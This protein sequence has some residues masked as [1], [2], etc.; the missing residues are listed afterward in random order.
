MYNLAEKINNKKSKP[1]ELVLYWI[2]GV[3]YIIKYNKITIGLDLYL[4]DSCRN[5]KDEFKRI[6]P[7]FIGPEELKLDYLIATHDHGDHFDHGSIKG[8]VNNNTNTKLLGPD[9]VVKTARD[10]GID[11]LKLIKFNRGN[12]IKINEINYTAVPSDHGEY[13]PDCIGIIIKMGGKNIYFTSD[14]CYRDDFLEMVD[15]KEKIDVLIVPING[16]FGNPDAKDASKIT[17]MV[18]PRMVIP[19]HFWMFAE[20]GGDPG[21]F[22]E[23]CSKI[24]P[25]VKMILPA[26]GEELIF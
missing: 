4:S 1:G 18:K 24:A 26:I 6:I 23:Q 8:M 11:S 12:S 14:T 16:K 17:N 2:G 20:H 3:S 10:L 21:E 9:S 15:L 19:C 7:Q 5:K 13:S 22:K 25:G